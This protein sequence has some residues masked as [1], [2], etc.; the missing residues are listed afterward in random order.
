MGFKLQPEEN[1]VEEK[2][3][4]SSISLRLKTLVKEHVGCIFFL[5]PVIICVHLNNKHDDIL[6]KV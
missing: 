2:V 3:Q 5:S 4:V 1:T 6:H